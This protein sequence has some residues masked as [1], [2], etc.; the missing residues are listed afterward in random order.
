MNEHLSKPVD[1]EKI[2]ETLAK[3][4]TAKGTTGG[5]VTGGDSPR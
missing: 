2:T 4:L 3:L 1:I 5:E